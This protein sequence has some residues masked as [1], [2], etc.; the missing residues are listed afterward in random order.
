M[1]VDTQRK[2]ILLDPESRY[3]MWWLIEEVA[4]FLEIYGA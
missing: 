1:A 2:T 3:D 4:A